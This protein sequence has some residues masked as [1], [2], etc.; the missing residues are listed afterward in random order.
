MASQNATIITMK[1]IIFSYVTRRRVELGTSI[2]ITTP[3]QRSSYISQFFECKS[4]EHLP[5]GRAAA[6]AGRYQATDQF[7]PAFIFTSENPNIGLNQTYY[8]IYTTLHTI[9]LLSYLHILISRL[10]ENNI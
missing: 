7:D 3:S 4:R 10:Q 6:P 9:C 8:N 5:L 1:K 2:L